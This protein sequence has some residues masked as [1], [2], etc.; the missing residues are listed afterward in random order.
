MT[1]KTGKIIPAKIQHMSLTKSGKRVPLGYRSLR[2]YVKILVNKVYYRKTYMIGKENLPGKGVPTLV[3]SN[4]QNAMCDA[5]GILFSI[6]KRLVHFL[7]RADIFSVGKRLSKFL[8][9][10]GL[11]PAYRM[12]MDGEEAVKNNGATFAETEAELLDGETVVIFPE[13]RHQ[14]KR[15]LGE[16]SSGYTKMA[17]EAAEK[18]GFEKEIFILPACNHYS[19]YFGFRTQ[20]LIRFG[21]PVSLKPYYELYK[22]RP[23]TAQR[24]VN[25]K[26]RETIS[27]MM[28]NIRDLEN[29]EA[30]DFLRQGIYGDNFAIINGLNPKELPQKL[31]ADKL[32]VAKLDEASAKDPEKL[33]TLYGR[34]NELYK[35]MGKLDLPGDIIDEAPNALSVIGM[36]LGLLLLL[37][38]AFACLW[39]ALP[40]W[41]VPA[42]LN[43]VLKK[44]QATE[45]FKSTFFIAVDSLL[46]LPVMGVLTFLLTW[47]RVGW[48][49]ALVNASLFPLMCMFEWAYMHWLH[50]LWRKINYLRAKRKGQAQELTAERREIFLAFD[51]ILGVNTAAARRRR[52]R[53]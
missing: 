18:S 48:I 50:K 4:H 39:P 36:A 28:L 40:C 30:I 52:R 42:Y 5:L 31:E 38:V 24:Q 46:L 27:S 25:A 32:L 17:F 11:L 9:A 45:N 12:S 16:F 49:V 26:V 34:V 10:I 22:T 15:W 29:Y 7:V 41:F 8:R 1:E 35:K 47:E 2:A 43:G 13:G 51:G 20:M 23:R 37:P 6:D 53:N 19:E 44:R 33:K 14:E 21:A 3:V